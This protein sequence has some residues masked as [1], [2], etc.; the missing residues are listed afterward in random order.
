MMGRTHALTGAAAGL[1][2]CQLHPNLTALHTL[3]IAA[4]T[5]GA[6]LWPDLDHPQSTAAN[7][8]GPLTRGPSMLIAALSGGHRQ[9]THSIL[10]ILT[11]SALTGLAVLAGGIALGLW[12]AFLAALGS[13]SVMGRSRPGMIAHVATFLVIGGLATTTSTF[14]PPPAATLILATMTGTAVHIAG[15]MITEEGC[16]LLWPL[17]VRVGVGLITT[18]G[19]AER[20]IIAPA[21]FL[22]TAVLGYHQLHSTLI[23][24][25]IHALSEVADM[26]WTWSQQ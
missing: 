18:A 26:L 4:I 16:P 2:L 22:A 12:V 14:T 8:A 9:G 17:P 1:V 6:A 13:A 23:P 19:T 25:S 11:A 7:A 5:A 3:T 21:A 15:D 10:G 24:E 20:W